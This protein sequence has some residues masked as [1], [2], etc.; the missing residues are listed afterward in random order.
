MYLGQNAQDF[1]EYDSIAAPNFRT[2][3]RIVATLTGS[4]VF[5]DGV[6]REVWQE[7]VYATDGAVMCEATEVTV[8]CVIRSGRIWEVPAERI[9]YVR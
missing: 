7:V 3:D 1:G 2:A 9:S 6:A 4:R 8:D 5:P